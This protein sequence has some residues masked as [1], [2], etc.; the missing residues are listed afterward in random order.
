MIPI[1][2]QVCS[3]EPSIQ[4]KELGV[5]QESVWYWYRGSTTDASYSL[6]DTADVMNNSLIPLVK[7]QWDA[8]SAYTVA[9]LGELLVNY[10]IGK[11]QKVGN[12]WVIGA[13]RDRDETDRNG[14]NEY[15]V[16]RVD[17]WDNS[18]A[19]ARAKMLIYLLENKLIKVEDL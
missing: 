12:K 14:I 7:D 8:F 19:N 5:P 4:L 10:D 13:V 11:I 9:E 17:I 6:G 18:E 15:I 2:Q 1:E 3:L 16:K